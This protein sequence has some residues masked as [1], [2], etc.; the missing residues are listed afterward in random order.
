MSPF[1]GV[2]SVPRS[3]KMLSGLRSLWQIPLLCIWLTACKTYLA[4]IFISY[5]SNFLFFIIDSKE[6]KLQYSIT[7][8]EVYVWWLMYNSYS[9]QMLGCLRHLVLLNVLLTLS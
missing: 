2:L 6:L 5:S 4:T 7:K 8:N 3:T 1:V 9:W